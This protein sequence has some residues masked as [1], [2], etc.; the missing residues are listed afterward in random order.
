MVMMMEEYKIQTGTV[1]NNDAESAE[2]EKAPLE[3]GIRVV[4]AKSQA[5]SRFRKS[6]DDA[7]ANFGP[8]LRGKA[9]KELREFIRDMEIIEDMSRAVD[10]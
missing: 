9:R 2:G 6:W 8:D 3:T 4:D 10:E 7:E 1:G 5:Q